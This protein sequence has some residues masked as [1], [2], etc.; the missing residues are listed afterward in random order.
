[1]LKSI[2]FAAILHKFQNRYNR[3]SNDFSNDFPE[4]KDISTSEVKHHDPKQLVSSKKI[5]SKF[6]FFDISSESE[7]N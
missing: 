2:T 5:K 7:E 6:N 4:L 3:S 1:M